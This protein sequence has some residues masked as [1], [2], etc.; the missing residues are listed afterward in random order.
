[1]D[2]SPLPS[3]SPTTREGLFVFL[4]RTCHKLDTSRETLRIDDDV[5]LVDPFEQYICDKVYSRN[6]LVYCFGRM[7][8][9][10]RSAPRAKHI[11]GDPRFRLVE[12][13][14]YPR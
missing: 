6:Y 5:V 12:T 11:G 14:G 3:F 2:R 4:V 7:L 13:L 1:M 8:S 10:L 9:S